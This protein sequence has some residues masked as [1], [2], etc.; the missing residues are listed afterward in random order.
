[1]RSHEANKFSTWKFW[2]ERTWEKA[3]KTLI[4]IIAENFPRCG[5]DIDI[6]IPKA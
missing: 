1:M 3:R 2:K 5:R 4:K 6:Q